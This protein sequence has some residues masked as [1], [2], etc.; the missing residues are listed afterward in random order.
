MVDQD[1]LQK[2]IRDYVA[3]CVMMRSDKLSPKTK[4][5]VRD[6]TNNLEQEL[7]KAR[8]TTISQ[9]NTA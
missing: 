3:F 2:A 7:T 6:L 8:Q 4:E 5:L 1:Y 9:L